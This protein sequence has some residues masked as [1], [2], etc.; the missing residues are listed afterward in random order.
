MQLP[1]FPLNSYFGIAGGLGCFPFDLDLI[2]RSLAPRMSPWRWVYLDSVSVSPLVKRLSTLHDSYSEAGQKLFR[3]EPAIF[4]FDWNFS[5]THTSSKHFS[6]CPGSVSV[7]SYRC[8]Q[9][10]WVVAVSGRRYRLSPF[11]DSFRYGSVSS[12][13][14]PT[15][16]T[17]RSILQGTPSHITNRLLVSTRF[18]VLLHS[19]KCFF[20]FPHGTGSLSVTR[21]VSLARWSADSDEF[22]TQDTLGVQISFRIRGSHPHSCLP[23]TTAFIWST[24]ESCNPS[25]HA[26]WFGVSVSLALL[27]ES[28]F[29]P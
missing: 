11:S 2:T 20:T 27:R 7:A 14:S 3:R 25:V 21:D 10:T 26:H 15:I 29:F 16:V 28:I 24:L 9:P 12:T 8:L 13:T 6:T 1:S 23:A 19:S 18:Q 17:R 4:K 5:A 22:I